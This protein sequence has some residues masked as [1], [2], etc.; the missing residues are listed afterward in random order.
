[1]N[2]NENLVKKNKTE[3]DYDEVEDDDNETYNDDN[4]S[5]SSNN[6]GDDAKKRLIKIMMFI[7]IGTVCFI[8]ILF[9]LSLFTKKSYKYNEVEEI[10]SNAAKEYFNDHP[11]SLPKEDGSVVEIDSSNLVVEVKM[12]DLSEYLKDGK[13]CTG[14]VQVEKIGAD[15][16]YSPYLN[17]GTDYITIELYK[18][19]VNDNNI[20]TSGNGLYSRGGAYH[21]RGEK[22]NN[23]VRLDHSLWRVVKVTSDNNIAL[24]SDS[25]VGIA[26]PWDDRY[27]EATGLEN[28]KNIYK[29]SRIKDY[30]EDVYKKVYDED[31]NIDDDGY[32]LS[33][34]SIFTNKDKS[35]LDSYNLCVGKN[36]INNTEKDNSIECKD[37]L[38]NQKIGLLTLSD[39]LYASLDEKCTSASSN[40]CANYNYLADFDDDWWLATG[41][42]A[43]TMSVYYV[44]K[45]GFVK[46]INASSL[47]DVRPVIYLNSRALYKSG[48]GTKDDPYVLK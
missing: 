14:S 13:S 31:S 8:F 12:K 22:L 46:S 25:S 39:Y 24:I 38:K 7:V 15:Y 11:E 10:L 44:N 5:S 3:I 20:V 18:K 21:Y 40:S 27:N 19:I 45:S 23:Y 48:T 42:S 29:L 6:N 35:K 9:V 17:C 47:G 28:G 2:V 41:N 26:T 1:M 30:F 34:D 33:G 32:V 36:G 16:V 43:D 4:N 37:V